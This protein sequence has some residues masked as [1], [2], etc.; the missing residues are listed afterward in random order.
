[1]S[2]TIGELASKSGLSIDEA[3]KGLGALLS[4]LK[5]V[6][7]AEIFSR[8]QAAVPDAGQM[9][10]GAEQSGHE[11]SGG[12]LGAITSTVGKLFGGGDSAAVAKLSQMG[13]SAEQLQQFLP[14]AL[15]FL[16][17]R[18]PA[19]VME[20]ISSLIPGAAAAAKTDR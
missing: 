16:K 15:E 3:K 20:R 6:L 17:A 2:E 14:N 11:A 4:S 10:T 12:V 1:M 5:G 7:P 9:M 19:D 18:L 13:F 8:V